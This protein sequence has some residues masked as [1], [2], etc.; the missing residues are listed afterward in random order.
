MKGVNIMA[1]IVRH[2][3]NGQEYVLLG[4]GFGAYKASRPSFFGGNLFPNEEEG[5]YRMVAVSDSNGKINWVYSNDLEVVE[6]DGVG[7]RDVLKR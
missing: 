1:I 4:A 3:K 6:V 7:I 2:L 5:T